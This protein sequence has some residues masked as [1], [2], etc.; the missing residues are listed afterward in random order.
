M[1]LNQPYLN[2]AVG[3]TL[4]AVLLS[5]G[6]RTP[7]DCSLTVYD[8][9]VGQL[10][11]SARLVSLVYKAVLADCFSCT[12]ELLYRTYASSIDLH[13]PVTDDDH[14]IR[15]INSMSRFRRALAY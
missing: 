10:D 1:L 14:P 3:E 9:Q 4:T 15:H 8:A 5:D 11:S 7:R 6:G 13:C 12:I 2:S